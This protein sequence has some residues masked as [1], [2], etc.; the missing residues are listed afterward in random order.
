MDRCCLGDEG[1]GFLLVPWSFGWVLSWPVAGVCGPSWLALLLACLAFCTFCWR[2]SL[3][4]FTIIFF[5]ESPCFCEES[6]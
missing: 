5:G 6:E 4:V 1:F 3:I 2:G